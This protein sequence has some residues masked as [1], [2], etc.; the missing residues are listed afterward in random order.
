MFLLQL[1]MFVLQMA[2]TT[3]LWLKVSM[4]WLLQLASTT[5]LQLTMFL[6]E[7]AFTTFPLLKEIMF[8]LQLA[9]LC[10]IWPLSVPLVF[11]V[12]VLAAVG[13]HHLLFAAVG[14]LLAGDFL[15]HLPLA[16]LNYVPWGS[17]PPPPSS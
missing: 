2:P 9:I 3:F 11:V 4:F 10:G 1:A 16:A 5:V 15:H 13:L 17:L 14:H 6:L 12:H 7:L 8:L